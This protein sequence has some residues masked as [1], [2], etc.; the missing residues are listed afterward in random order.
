MVLEWG[1]RWISICHCCLGFRIV[2]SYNISIYIPDLV[3]SFYCAF[4]I[5]IWLEMSF[6]L[7]SELSIYTMML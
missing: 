2:Y 3:K 1:V 5:E 7:W 4:D 6:S